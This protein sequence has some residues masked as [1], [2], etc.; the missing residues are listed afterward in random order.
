MFPLLEKKSV[1]CLGV[2]FLLKLIRAQ[3]GKQACALFQLHVTSRARCHDGGKDESKTTPPQTPP[4][5]KK[6]NIKK[7]I[8][9]L[10]QRSVLECSRQVYRQVSHLWSRQMSGCKLGLGL[11]ERN[12]ATPSAV[13]L[14]LLHLSAHTVERQDRRLHVIVSH[15]GQAGLTTRAT[16]GQPHD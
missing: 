5:L 2:F 8:I 9:I 11:T 4:P 15:R 3:K 16:S 1:F 12:E 14:Y 13:H 7:I 10:M 6:K